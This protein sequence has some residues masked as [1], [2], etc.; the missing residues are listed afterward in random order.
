VKVL[1]AV[2]LTVASAY[3]AAVQAHAHKSVILTEQTAAP[4]KARVGD[5][6]EIRLK[7]QPG[8]GFSW[9]PKSGAANLSPL[10]ALKG[11]AIPGGWQTQRFR[12]VAKWPGTYRLIFAYE[13]PWAGG[14]KA[15]R[16]KRFTIIVS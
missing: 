10:P 6:V 14:T 7:S 2:I 5:A 15:A 11:Q 8:T 3:P 12:F 9:S 13:Q 16:T 1:A 4:A